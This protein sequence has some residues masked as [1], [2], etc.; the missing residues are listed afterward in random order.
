M[1]EDLLR[2]LVL[3][4]TG[5]YMQITRIDKPSPESHVGTLREGE[6]YFKD[7]MYVA[8]ELLDYSVISD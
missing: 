8:G 4:T 6:R 5:E 7:R 2:N 3:R 1:L